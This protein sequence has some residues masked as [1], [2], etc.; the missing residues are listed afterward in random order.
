[1]KFFDDPKALL[2]ETNLVDRFVR[3]AGVHTT[4][5]GNSETC[6]ST[7]RQF[8]LARMLVDELKELGL[9]D[10]AVDD[11]CYVTAT[12]PG[13]GDNVVGLIAH[14]DTSPAAPGENVEP[15]FHESY[16]GKVI[17]LK[18]GIKIDPADNPKLKECVGDTVLTS[19]G[20]TLLGADDKAGIAEIMT[21][22][23]YYQKHPDTPHPTIKV[24]FTPDEEIGRGHARFPIDAFG[25]DVA[26]TLD[27]T[28]DG[29]INIETFEAYSAWVTIKGV[30]TH[31]GSGK[32]KL[33]N[34]L[35]YLAKFLEKL[36]PKLAPEHTEDREGFIHP[37]EIE[38]DASQCKCHLIVRD[39][40]EEKVAKWCEIVKRAAAETGEEEPRLKV[41]VKCEFSYPNMAKFLKQKPEISERLEQ[42]VRKAGIEPNMIPIRGGTDGSNL[43]RKG[44]PTPNIFA[45]GMEFHGPT[46]WISTRSMGL[47]LCTVLNLMSLYAE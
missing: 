30:S 9:K 7:E 45:G 6:P 44:L 35:R 13:K 21:A 33:V 22:L 27:G 37:F 10:A 43:S 28:F 31:P 20:T 3:Y 15:V 8:D 29:E 12:L 18:D 38:G 1:M 40:E 41:D 26:F 42:A 34:A 47:A 5:D 16:D 32:G 4:S 39:F 46:E 11:N 36:P 19:D 25:A 2:D 24:G 17:E 23:E 14:L